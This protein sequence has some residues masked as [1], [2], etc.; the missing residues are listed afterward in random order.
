MTGIGGGMLLSMA[1]YEGHVTMADLL[2]AAAG[3]AASVLRRECQPGGTVDGG[4][5]LAQ[6][7]CVNSDTP[8]AF[9]PVIV[10]KTT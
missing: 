10:Y 1:S 7:K 8:H 4:N 9:P 2:L 6:T 5:I 3:R